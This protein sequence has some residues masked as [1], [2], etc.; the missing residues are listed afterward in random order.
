MSSDPSRFAGATRLQPHLG[1]WETKP[2]W[3]IVNVEER[4]GADLGIL[5][6]IWG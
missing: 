5:L 2:G 4:D 1:G 3:T 6:G